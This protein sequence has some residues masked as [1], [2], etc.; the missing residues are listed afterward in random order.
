MITGREVAVTHSALRREILLSALVSAAAD[1]AR[2]NRRGKSVEPRADDH[3]SARAAAMEVELRFSRAE[4]RQLPAR[5]RPEPAR[6]LLHACAL[7]AWL[8]ERAAPL[9]HRSLLRCRLGNMVV[10]QW[11]RFRSGCLR[12]SARR[13]LRPPGR[14]NAALRRCRSWPQ[15]ACHHRH[16]R[17]RAGE[18]RAD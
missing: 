8:H 5:R 17:R 4:R 13:Q 7:V 9:H 10:Q 11:S 16:L 14:W 6:S 15:R 18:L 3:S 1:C 2:R 12:S